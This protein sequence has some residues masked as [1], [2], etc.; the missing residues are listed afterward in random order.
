MDAVFARLVGTGGDDG[1]WS[2]TADDD[3]FAAQLGAVP[4]LDSGEK[5]IHIRVQD[6]TLAIHG[7]SKATCM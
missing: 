5:G 7:Y 2:I 1:P 6:R 3:R 4:L